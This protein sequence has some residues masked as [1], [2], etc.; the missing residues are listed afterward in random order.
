MAPPGYTKD[1]SP[2]VLAQR[3][4]QASSRLGV[5]LAPA[6]L[7]AAEESERRALIEGLP[8]MVTVFPT[9]LR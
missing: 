4:L 7:T 1:G 8:D 2:L 3:L 6:A 5:T 9:I